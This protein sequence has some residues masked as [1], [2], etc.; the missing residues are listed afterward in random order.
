MLFFKI[1][2]CNENLKAIYENYAG[3]ALEKKSDYT[4]PF[5]GPQQLTAFLQSEQHETRLNA[6]RIVQEAF[7]GPVSFYEF[8]NFL[9]SKKYNYLALTPALDPN[10]P[11]NHYF[12][13]SSHNTY[14]SGNQLTSDSK[15]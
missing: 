4:T 9:S 3:V 14:L 13:Y 5:M 10:L 8:C 1:A 2:S 7:I 12:C 11:L 6:A 15:I